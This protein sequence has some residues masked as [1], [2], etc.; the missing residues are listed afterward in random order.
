MKKFVLTFAGLAFAA[1]LAVVFS[2][3]K[4]VG[5][6]WVGCTSTLVIALGSIWATITDPSDHPWE[7]GGIFI[8]GEVLLSAAIFVAGYSFLFLA[9]PLAIALVYLFLLVTKTELPIFD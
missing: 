2:P 4:L 6:D 8:I 3:A 9:I 1:I 5:V 7:R